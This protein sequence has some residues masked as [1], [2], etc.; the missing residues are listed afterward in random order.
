MLSRGPSKCMS[1]SM[2]KHKLY[3]VALLSAFIILIH[4]SDA[5]CN[6]PCAK[7]HLNFMNFLTTNET[8]WTYYSTERTYPACK[9][10]L[11]HYI[12]W[13]SVLFKRYYIKNLT[14]HRED[15]TAN[16]TSSHPDLMFFA[17]A[18][19]CEQERL[20]YLGDT[21][22]CAV[23]SVYRHAACPY[24]ASPDHGEYFELR[25]YNS[26]TTTGP[27]TDCVQQFN[28]YGIPEKRVYSSDCQRILLPGCRHSPCYGG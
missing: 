21:H 24:S 15:L 8:I 19:I 16:I 3:F 11:F 27:D 10:Y 4:Y 25:V 5:N 2:G 22:K 28:R 17:A 18:G 13:G 1:Y 7:H 9:V 26:S 14:T 12:S 20:L 23:V 6:K